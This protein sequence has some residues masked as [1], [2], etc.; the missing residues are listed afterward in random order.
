[1]EAKGVLIF[2]DKGLDAINAK[3]GETTKAFVDAEKA[4]EKVFDGL[5]SDAKAAGD[6]VADTAGQVSSAAGELRTLEKQSQAS[7]KGVGFF[8]TAMSGASESIK[9]AINNIS[10]FGVSIG[11]ARERLSKARQSLAVY[12]RANRIAGASAQAA[13]KAS[14]LGFNLARVGALALRTALG[15]I[16]LILTAVVGAFTL[17]AGAAKRS[18]PIMNA[19]GQATAVVSAVVDVFVDRVTAVAEAVFFF[20]KAVLQFIGGNPDGAMESFA[21]ATDSA[22]VA[23]AS[24]SK[25]LSIE[26]ERAAKVAQV[27]QQ[28]ERSLF[29]L[30][31]RRAAANAQL[32][33]LN[34]I[35]EDITKS[36]R[37][38]IAAAEQFGKI[39]QGLLADELAARELAI[40][41]IINGGEVTD[42]LRA[43]IQELGKSGVAFQSIGDDANKLS[44]TLSDIG[45]G[46][47][48]FSDEEVKKLQEN[49]VAYFGL[50]ERSRESLTTQD[51]KRNTIEQLR[52][53]R[54]LKAIEA[55]RKAEEDL[56]NFQRQIQDQLTQL[57][58]D[59]SEGEDRI[60]LERK[61]AQAQIDQLEETARERFAAARQTFNLEKE[62]AELREGVDNDSEKRKSEFRVAENKKRIEA[63]RDRQLAELELNTTTGNLLLSRDE[64]LALERNKIVRKSLQDQREIAVKEFGEGSLEVLTIDVQLRATNDAD[65]GVNDAF[66]KRLADEGLARIE[67]RQKVQ[68][69][70]VELIQEVEEKELTAAQFREKRKNEILLSGLAERRGILVAQF[71]ENSAEVDL[72]DLETERLQQQIDALGNINLSPLDRIRQGIQK[73]FNLDNE[74]FAVLEEQAVG[75]FNSIVSGIE[76]IYERQLVEQDRIITQIDERVG[77]L[78]DALNAELELQEQGLANSAD[79]RQRELDEELR[80]K[81]IAETKRLEIEKRAARQQLILDGAKTASAY[82]LAVAQLVA[83]EAFKGIA[84]IITIGA[85]IASIFAIAAQARAQAAQFTTVPSFREGTGSFEGVLAGPSHEGG[86]ILG[87]Y[88]RNGRTY[89]AEMEGGEAV[90]PVAQSRKYKPLLEAVRTDALS[91]MSDGMVMNLLG[92]NP[93][94]GISNRATLPTVVSN[95]KVQMKAAQMIVDAITNNL[96]FVP[97]GKGGYRIVDPLGGRIGRG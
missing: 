49:V 23:T 25:E 62:F 80:Q 17:L 95:E 93:T 15:P 45:D 91:G 96:R 2:E 34:K 82:G 83:A 20:N 18:E 4:K 43:K 90:T 13:G 88:T 57:A 58:V 41:A 33:G 24:L 76:A 32:K 50:Q 29:N 47:T 97:D 10:L 94:R 92:R 38:R 54:R 68:L 11:D 26:I 5:A 22:S 71:G 77:V 6:A 37:E 86:G 48:V 65:D 64:L 78:Q 51:N 21:R 36:D 19:F 74:T 53:Q 28:V 46:R 40:A 75:A 27:N 63:E 70:E 35:T 7:G 89:V 12:S 3:L 72:V 52:E 84:A 60:E 30:E 73:A 14:V 39:E 8:R 9:G 79:L 87:R 44:T 59:N 1:M 16:G 55:R 42:D 69:A 66:K 67:S 85:G 56:F 81:E 61:V 31:I